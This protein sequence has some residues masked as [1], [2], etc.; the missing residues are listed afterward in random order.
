MTSMNPRMRI[1]FL[2]GAVLPFSQEWEKRWDANAGKCVGGCIDLYLCS[3]VTPPIM[4]SMNPRMRIGFLI[5][6]VLPFSQE[7]EKRWMYLFINFPDH[8]PHN[9]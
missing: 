1:G 4:T 6:A 5:G 9:N 2:I 7:W 3:P 8:S